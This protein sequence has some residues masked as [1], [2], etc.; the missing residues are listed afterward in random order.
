[1]TEDKTVSEEARR[2][3]LIWLVALVNVT[4]LIWMPLLSFQRGFTAQITIIATAALLLVLNG[5]IWLGVRLKRA[6]VKTGRPLKPLLFF[7][8]G[9]LSA[10]DAIFE[11]IS[12][13]YGSAGLLLFGCA[14]LIWLGFITKK[15]NAKGDRS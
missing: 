13:D 9:G 7:V 10:A 12:N 14:S 11:L 4:V 15:N 1:M 6:R 8:I 3:R 2:K 5:A